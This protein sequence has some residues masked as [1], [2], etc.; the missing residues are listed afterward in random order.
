[1]N[2]VY[3]DT[4]RAFK[5]SLHLGNEKPKCTF[6][7]WVQENINSFLL[8][9]KTKCILRHQKILE[10]NFTVTYIPVL[11][12]G[13]FITLMGVCLSRLLFQL[14]MRMYSQGLVF[15]NI[16]FQENY[17]QNELCL[18]VK[19][20]IQLFIFLLKFYNLLNCCLIDQL[21]E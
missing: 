1:M 16:I 8:S 19:S 5:S 3:I 2:Y 14:S 17:F 9:A 7:I 20:N 4:G 12:G 11:I 10:K 21:I 18:I 15:P 13:Y 6:S